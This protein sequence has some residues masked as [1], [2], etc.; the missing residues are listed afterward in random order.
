MKD[1]PPPPPPPPPPASLGAEL[2][3]TIAVEE[4][5]VLHKVTPKAKTKV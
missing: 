5:R 4:D 1:V 3:K 2:V